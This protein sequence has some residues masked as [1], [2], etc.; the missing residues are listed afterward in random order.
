MGIVAR[1]DI[2]VL[3]VSG[4]SY[5]SPLLLSERPA[6][7]RKL[8]P[9]VT[10][11]SPSEISIR[12]INI[13]AAGQPRVVAINGCQRKGSHPIPTRRPQGST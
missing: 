12:K 11:A 5:R 6:V 3:L 2:V 7:R 8:R 13:N 4:N 10:R 9:A 1:R